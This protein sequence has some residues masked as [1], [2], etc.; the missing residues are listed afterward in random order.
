MKTHYIPKLLLRQF[1][2]SDKVNTYNFFN[3]NFSTKKLRQVFSG[4]DL[5]DSELEKAFATKLEGP[6]GDLL[7]HKLLSK[8]KI[9][10]TRKENLLLRKFLMINSLRSPIKN[11]TWEEMIEHTRLQNHPYTQTREF[12]CRH[13]PEYE[14]Q[15]K[16][17]SYSKENYISDLKKIMELESLE[18][19]GEQKN[20]ERMP[21]WLQFSVSHAMATAIAF[22]DCTDTGQEFILTK[23]IGISQMDYLG[24]FHKCLMI[25][26]IKQKKKKEG[27][28]RELR[29]E[30]ERLEWGSIVFAEN[31]SVYPISPTRAIICFSP[32]FRAFFPTMDA[33]GKKE[34][35]SAL[36][37]KEQFDRHF[38]RPMRMELFEPCRTKFNQE[39]QYSVKKLEKNEVLS[40]NAILLDMET[41]EF[42]FHDYN[43]IRDS[44]WYYDKIE[45]FALEKKHDFSHLG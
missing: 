37:E 42:V 31:F 30:L 19:M 35:Y 10:I 40:I 4:E 41:E 16:K 26:N 13:H 21:I 11:K 18:E 39:Y 27:I 14:E 17:E 34:R 1:S 6:F 7:N 25:N 28:C 33:W 20:R 36:L 5:F 15:L 24:N 3:K 22:W 23:L 44:F 2:I 38:Y 9:S 43:K 45:K 29:W 8:D 32:Y 12:L